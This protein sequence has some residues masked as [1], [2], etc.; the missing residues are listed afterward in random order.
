MEEKELKEF[1][2]GTF[3][4]VAGGYDHSAMRFFPDSAERL[5]SYLDLSGDE[6]VLDVA[7]G[8]GVAAM[9]LASSLPQGQVTGIDFSEGMLGQARSK[10]SAQGL[11][12]VTLLEMDMQDIT[13]ANDHFDA[14]VCCFGLFFV[15]D[16]ETQL[17]HMASKVK[18]GGKIAITSFY[19]TSFSPLVDIF[20][21]RLEC[22][23]IN[24]PTMAW[25]RVATRD[26]C[27]SIFSDAGL[28]DVSAEK[29][30]CG[31]ALKDPEEWW[32]IVWN[33]GFR[34]LVNQLDDTD[35]HKFKAEHLAEIIQ[36]SDGDGIKMEMGIIYTVGT[37]A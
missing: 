33:G 35:L 9:A 34:G 1:F 36:K 31:Y 19:D 3:N 4:T 21:S 2:K 27:I 29:I 6:H 17:R 18:S 22:Y 7:T 15:T 20:F 10:I 37:K 28:E 30:D 13:L 23:G 14:A 11:K 26:Q 24:P 32:H 5:P 12:N 16:M 25:K 8:T